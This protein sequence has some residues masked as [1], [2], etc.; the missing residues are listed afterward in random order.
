MVRLIINSSMHVRTRTRGKTLSTLALRLRGREDVCCRGTERPSH[1]QDTPL[2]YDKES[3]VARL[4]VPLETGTP[5]PKPRP[6]PRGTVLIKA[7]H[8]ACT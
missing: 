2:L 8:R 4:Y 3:E 5:A 6:V 7:R 1:V